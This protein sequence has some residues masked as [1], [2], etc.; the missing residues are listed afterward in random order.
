[1]RQV[2]IEDGE[3]RFIPLTMDCTGIAARWC[4]IHGDCTDAGPDVDIEFPYSDHC[5][6]EDCPLHGRN[7]T[8]AESPR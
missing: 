1:M 5:S 6:D 7:S 3:V 8:H 2:Y 4:P